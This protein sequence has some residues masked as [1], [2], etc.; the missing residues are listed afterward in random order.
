MKVLR[1]DSR[2]QFH[3]TYSGDAQLRSTFTGALHVVE[4][5]KTYTVGAKLTPPNYKNGGP[6]PS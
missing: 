2:G 5:I 3:Q 6:R 4:T 1:K